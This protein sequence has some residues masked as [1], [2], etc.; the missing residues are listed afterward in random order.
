MTR[1]SLSLIALLAISTT[2]FAQKERP[3]AARTAP[4]VSR[5]GPGGGPLSR[6]PGSQLAPGADDRF[7]H[8][9]VAELTIGLATR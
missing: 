1:R 6:R 4:L 3:R 2:A 8:S 7:A 5:E 9:D